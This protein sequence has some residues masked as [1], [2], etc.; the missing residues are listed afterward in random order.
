MNGQTDSHPRDDGLA[1]EMARALTSWFERSARALPWRH[2]PDPYRVWVAEVMLQQTTVAACIPRFERFI[3]R[4]PDIRSLA[5]APL[6][7]VLAEWEGL[8]Y[9]TRAR[10][11]WRAAGMVLEEYGGR[12]PSD[13]ESLRRLPGIGP[14]TAGAIRSIAFDLPAGMVDA[15]IRRVLGRVCGIRGAGAE[16]EREVRQMCFSVSSAGSPR[17]VN[18]ALM[19]LGS[20]VCLPRSP[21]CGECPL[22]DLCRAR[23]E[24]SF[25]CWHGSVPQA[26]RTVRVEEVCVTASMDGLWLVSRPCDGRWRGM[27]EFPRAR[28]EAG[29]SPEL[30]ARALLE[31]DFGLQP[32][33]LQQ[34]GSLRYRVTVH[35]T[36]LHVFR[37]WLPQPPSSAVREW[38]LCTPAELADVPLPNPM[39]R[40]A[41]SLGA[42]GRDRLSLSVEKESAGA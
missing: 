19:E 6:E 34:T 2:Q 9:Y 1:K 38:R 40:I 33:G 27:W 23:R 41:R 42:E 36:R 18:Q 13:L 39:R 30:E 26:S 8:G 31:R 17:T 24:Q 35:D 12:L 25:D 11:L 14:Y 7:E 16:A 29:S 32:S 28:V 21:L 20:L 15:N 37:A 10:N 5:S 4:F 3:R 22:E